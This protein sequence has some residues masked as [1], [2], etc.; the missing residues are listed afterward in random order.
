VPRFVLPQPSSFPPSEAQ[1]GNPLRGSSVEVRVG[2]PRSTRSREMTPATSKCVAWALQAWRFAC[3][4]RGARVS[5]GRSEERGVAAAGPWFV[6]RPCSRR[7]RTLALCSMPDMPI[8]TL[9]PRISNWAG[10]RIFDGSANARRLKRALTHN[11]VVGRFWTA[12]R[13]A[14]EAVCLRVGL[15]KFRIWWRFVCPIS[16]SPDY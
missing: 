1:S 8:T 16:R 2:F 3:R 6:L 10:A 15:N 11:K 7:S 13:A 4:V 5:G 14:E 12:A 9:C